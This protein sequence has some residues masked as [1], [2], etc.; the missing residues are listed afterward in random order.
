MFSTEGLV[1]LTYER[2]FGS[3]VGRVGAYYTTIAYTKNG[4][5][6]EEDIENDEFELVEE[7]LVDYD[8]E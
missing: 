7:E 1:W 8:E 5:D 6:Y 4:I 2:C 3:L